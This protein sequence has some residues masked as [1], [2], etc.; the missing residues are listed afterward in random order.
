[1]RRIT[2][3]LAILLSGCVVENESSVGSVGESLTLT[4]RSGGT[5][6]GGAERCVS[7]FWQPV[8]YEQCANGLKASRMASVGTYSIGVTEVTRVPN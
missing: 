5:R 1:M 4:C 3:V 8:G 6:C 7:G 2:L